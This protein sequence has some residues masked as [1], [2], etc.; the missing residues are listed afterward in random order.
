MLT[1]PRQIG[2]TAEEVESGT[3][4]LDTR[5]RIAHVAESKARSAPPVEPETLE[6][7]PVDATTEPVSDAPEE[8][9]PDPFAGLDPVDVAEAG[10]ADAAADDDEIL[11]LDELVADAPSAPTRF[12]L[13]DDDRAPA[14]DAH[15]SSGGEPLAHRLARL[16]AKLYQSRTRDEV[17]AIALE[18]ASSFCE[19]AALFVVRGDSVSLFRAHGEAPTVVGDALTI[20]INMPSL[21]T[22]PAQTGLPFRGAPP[23]GGVDGRVLEGLGREAAQEILVHPV[24]IRD[25]VVNLLYADNGS[26]N[27]A[28][29]SIGAL[30]ALS[31]TL[32][33]AY[34]RLIADQKR[35]RHG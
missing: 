6:L 4:V 35:Q 1:R 8:P 29:T 17:I 24:V 7:P 28:E 13:E 5:A 2:L 11:L 33:R 30:T 9:R 34:E 12:E 20:P 10:E 21:F 23:S 3:P 14:H 18:I 27:F 26:E 22:H 16:E 19:S 25:R 15:A 31:H 32:S